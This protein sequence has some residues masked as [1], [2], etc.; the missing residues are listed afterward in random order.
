M[1]QVLRKRRKDKTL[2]E[3]RTHEETVIVPGETD[4]RPLS[5]TPDEKE[6]KKGKG[7]QTNTKTEVVT[8]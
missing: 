1:L 6:A 8:E 2:K 7:N 4:E 3:R 5:E